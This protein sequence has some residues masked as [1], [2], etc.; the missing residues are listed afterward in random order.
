MKLFS[1]V[2]SRTCKAHPCFYKLIKPFEIFSLLVNDLEHLCGWETHCPLRYI[3]QT[4]M[5]LLV[6][7]LVIAVLKRLRIW[8]YTFPPTSFGFS[9]STVM[10]WLV[11]IFSMGINNPCS[12]L[13]LLITGQ[14]VIKLDILLLIVKGS[15][16]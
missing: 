7:V 8:F 15:I 16:P 14:Q 4:L 3:G 12:C 5:F 1:F 11:N 2:S 6:L 9:C 10:I 13:L